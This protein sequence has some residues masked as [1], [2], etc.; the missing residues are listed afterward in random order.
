M[1]T[2]IKHTIQQWVP[3]TIDLVPSLDRLD[4][5]IADY[6]LLHKLAEVCSQKINSTNEEDVEFV[7]E[8]VKVVNLLYQAG[9]QYT[10][11]AIENEF[12]S[13]LS[14]EESPGILK[15]HIELFPPDL[16]KGYMKTILDTLRNA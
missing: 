16:R 11:N 8:V 15:K 14:F 4:D 9:N 6:L 7:K 12:L 1:K 5:Y 10:R 3:E 13:T 2:K